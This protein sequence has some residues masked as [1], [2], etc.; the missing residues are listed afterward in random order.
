[1][2][3]RNKNLLLLQKNIKD[4][5]ESIIG[6]HRFKTYMKG[7]VFV[8]HINDIYNDNCKF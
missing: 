3:K 7:I 4:S 2:V 6:A 1:M 5:Y 8:K